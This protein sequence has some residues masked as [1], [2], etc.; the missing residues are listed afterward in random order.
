M[1]CDQIINI[2]ERSFLEPGR[3]PGEVGRDHRDEILDELVRG[4]GFSEGLQEF[5]L[6]CLQPARNIIH[7]V[8]G[9]PKKDAFTIG[10]SGPT[11]GGRKMEV[12]MDGC[13]MGWMDVQQPMVAKR[14]SQPTEDTIEVCS[15]RSQT[16]P[17]SILCESNGGENDGMK[18]TGRETGLMG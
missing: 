13:G 6:S 14:C 12:W 17:T 16:L 3:C 9:I 8:A 15:F 5:T 7:L 18:L 4:Q 11:H 1:T 10:P 2:H